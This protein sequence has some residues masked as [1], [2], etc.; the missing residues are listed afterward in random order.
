MLSSVELVLGTPFS[1]LACAAAVGLIAGFSSG[2]CGVSPGGALVVLACALLGAGQHTAQGLSLAVQVAPTSLA[3]IARYRKDG[4][5][6][7]VRWLVPL[8]AGFVVGGLVGGLLAARASER[9]LQWSYVVY[10]SGLLALL[11][12]RARRA[13]RHERSTTQSS[14]QGPVGLGL[15]GLVA[16]VSSGFLGIGGGLAIVAGLSAGLRVSQHVA[17]MISLV[18]AAIPTTL[19]AAW[20]YWRQGLV[21]S[22]TVIG[23]I[24]VAL[25]L[26]TY[27]G[28]RAAVRLPEKMLRGVL[29]IVVTV[30][31]A[32]MTGKAVGWALSSDGVTHS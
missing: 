10:L 2:L 22:W 9:V 3:G 31:A 21:G 14:D 4:V 7:P 23:V 12:F 11:I 17:Q 32:Y 13:Q 1:V 26:G 24:I 18:L 27:L 20:V 30:M 28:A 29:V 19:P 5:R 16:G 6:F 25:W 8:A 15:V